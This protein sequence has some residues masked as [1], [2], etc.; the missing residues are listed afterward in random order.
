MLADQLAWSEVADQV[1][2]PKHHD[3]HKSK[4]REFHNGASAMD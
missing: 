3:S 2:E 1:A 4:Y